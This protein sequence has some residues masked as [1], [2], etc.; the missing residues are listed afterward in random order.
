MGIIILFYSIYSAKVFVSFHLALR[1]HC[2]QFTT[3]DTLHIIGAQLHNNLATCT[4]IYRMDTT[5]LYNYY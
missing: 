2:I 4:F 3:T 5:C 1:N